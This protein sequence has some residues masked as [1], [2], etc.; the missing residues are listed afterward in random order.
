MIKAIESDKFKIRHDDSV[1][2][3]TPVGKDAMYKLI[4]LEH[5]GVVKVR[6]SELGELIKLLEKA[7]EI[8]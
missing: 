8:F 7:Q 3:C 1:V 4:D 6:Y 5:C 2:V